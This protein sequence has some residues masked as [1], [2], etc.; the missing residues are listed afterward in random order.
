MTIG[1]IDKLTNFIMPV[2]ES[3]DLPDNQSSGRKKPGLRVHS[4]NSSD[5]KMVVVLPLKYEDVTGYADYLKAGIA[6]VVNF[7]HVDSYIQQSMIDFLSGVC[8]VVSGSSE[9]ISE[10]ILIYVPASVAINKELYAYSI[11]TYVKHKVEAN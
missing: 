7:S 2:E 1:L 6:I 11:P 10:R 4:N 3:L 8:Y 5:M 9:R